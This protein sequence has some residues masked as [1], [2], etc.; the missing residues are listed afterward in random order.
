[1]IKY[2]DLHKTMTR[3]IYVPIVGD[4]MTTRWAYEAMTVEQFRSNKYEK[5]FF[6]IDMRVSHNDWQASFLIPLLHRKSM[7]C[8]ITEGKP[9]Y[10]EHRANNLY[11]LNK[12]IPELSAKAGYDPSEV[13]NALN[14]HVYDSAVNAKVVGYLDSLKRYYRNETLLAIEERD[15]IVERIESENSIEYLVNLRQNNHNEFLSE[16]LLNTNSA[17]K[18]YENDKLIIQKA[19]PIFMEPGSRTGRAQMFA[20]YKI[21]GKTKIKTI[22][23]NVGVIWIMSFIL[24]IT[25]YFNTLQKIITFFERRWF[26]FRGIPLRYK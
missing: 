5:L 11:K 9:E 25:L 8:F 12:Y 17:E 14:R 26:R 21:V 23:F 6:D 22:W 24:G 7:E 18:L 20:P 1:M 15:S 10:A 16:I 2:D 3:K 19:D 13:L 4:M